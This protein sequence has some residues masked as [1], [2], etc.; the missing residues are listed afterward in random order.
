MTQANR[1][2]KRKG[3]LVAS[4]SK[5]DGKIDPLSLL[6]A[7]QFKFQPLLEQTYPSKETT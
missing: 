5:F 3:K 1:R 2:K 6:E 4:T 7:D